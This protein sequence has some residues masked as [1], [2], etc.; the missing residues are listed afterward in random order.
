MVFQVQVCQATLHGELPQKAAKRHCF[1]LVCHNVKIALQSPRD[2]IRQDFVTWQVRK[3]DET[4]KFLLH[5]NMLCFWKPVAVCFWKLNI[6][7]ATQNWTQNWITFCFANVLG[8]EATTLNTWWKPCQLWLEVLSL[9]LSLSF[10]LA[11][12]WS[13]LDHSICCRNLV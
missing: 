2:S 10:F 8:Q 13:Y 4:W 11:I 1:F 5:K 12:G 3:S 7:L 6:E 9:S